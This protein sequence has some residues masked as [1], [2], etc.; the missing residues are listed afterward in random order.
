MVKCSRI[1]KAMSTC[2]IKS[3]INDLYVNF[4]IES[5]SFCATCFSM[6][7]LAKRCYCF[8]HTY[9]RTLNT[10]QFHYILYKLL[11]ILFILIEDNSIYSAS[12]YLL[13]TISMTNDNVS[14]GDGDKVQSSEPP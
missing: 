11:C 12:L 9:T 5:H 4:R 13:V 6:D 8:K 7:M 14:Y 3:Y 10:I 2:I 1:K